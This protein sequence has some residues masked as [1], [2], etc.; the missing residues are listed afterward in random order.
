MR[1]RAT[2][3]RLGGNLLSPAEPRKAFAFQR[4]YTDDRSI[5]ETYE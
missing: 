1:M 5:F 3:D 4:V 2:P